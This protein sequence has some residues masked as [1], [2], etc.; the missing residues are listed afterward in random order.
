[1]ETGSAPQQAPTQAGGGD[2]RGA[3]AHVP[4]DEVNLYVTDGYTMASD[5][6]SCL[7]TNP[8]YADIRVT[9]LDGGVGA[10]TPDLLGGIDATP[11]EMPWAPDAMCGSTDSPPSAVA[12]ATAKG[13][14]VVVLVTYPAGDHEIMLI[15]AMDVLESVVDAM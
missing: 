13:S 12:Y 3:C 10:V 5:G 8:N 15:N 1:M 2:G 9:V 11:L 6:Q 4:L 14:A 7:L